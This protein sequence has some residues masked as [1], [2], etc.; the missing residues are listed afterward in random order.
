MTNQS[1]AMVQRYTYSSFGKIESQLDPNFLQP[2]RFTSRE[3][4]PET[5]LYHYR[6]RYY[7]PTIGRFLSE[8][9]IGFNRGFNLYGYVENNPIVW[10]D[11][12][13]LLPHTI[14]QQNGVIV[15]HYGLKDHGP[16]HRLVVGSV[17]L[18]ELY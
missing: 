16:A 15:D 17:R 3:L 18:A 7:D 12:L 4:D 8:D 11:P 1:G 6:E 10:T 2:Y 14:V 9:P 13:G 5:G